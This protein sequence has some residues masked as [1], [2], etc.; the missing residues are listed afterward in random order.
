MNFDEA[1]KLAYEA[2]ERGLEV[3]SVSHNY[4]EGKDE[5]YSI[6]VRALHDATGARGDINSREEFDK[7]MALDCQHARI[8]LEPARDG[9][10]GAMAT[11][12][13]CGDWVGIETQTS[14]SA[15]D[16]NQLFGNQLG[17]FLTQI[18]AWLHQQSLN[19]R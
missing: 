4:G 12:A 19:K 6:H 15:N 9:S 3:S 8:I 11:C 16:P 2:R 14:A 18:R 10:Y 1:V 7:L 13:L 17:Q 5:R